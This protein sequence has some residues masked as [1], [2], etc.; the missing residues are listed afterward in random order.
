MRVLIHTDIWIYS[1][2]SLWIDCC[3]EKMPNLN[4]IPN[5]I[6]MIMVLCGIFLYYVL[7]QKLNSRYT[8][9]ISEKVQHSSVLWELSQSRADLYW[10]FCSLYAHHHH[11]I[12]VQ[13]SMFIVIVM[14]RIQKIQRETKCSGV[15]YGHGCLMWMSNSNKRVDLFLIFRG[16]IVFLSFFMFDACKYVPF[17]GLLYFGFRSLIQSDAFD[18]QR[19]VHLVYFF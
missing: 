4:I 7:I 2:V 18:V 13:C 15:C 19:S 11:H 6:W 3:F 8:N 9:Y 14:V 5:A 17:S 1:K 12:H 16:L 10:S